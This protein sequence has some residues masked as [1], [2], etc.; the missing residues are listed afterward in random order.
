MSETQNTL[1]L[2]LDQP[3]QLDINIPNFEGKA[4]KDGR[5]GRDGDDA[6]R[7]AVRNGFSGT[8]KEW[9]ETLKGGNDVEIPQ[10]ILSALPQGYTKDFAGVIG[11]LVDKTSFN[12]PTAN[13]DVKNHNIL[14]GSANLITFKD[15]I[16]NTFITFTMGNLSETK[17]VEAGKEVSFTVTP[18]ADDT[19]AMITIK[20]VG[21]YTL[22]TIQMFIVDASTLPPENYDPS[23]GWENVF[24]FTNANKQAITNA[25]NN[26]ETINLVVDF[27]NSDT[28]DDD[29][30]VSSLQNVQNVKNILFNNIDNE[31]KIGYITI[32]MSSSTVY[33]N[34]LTNNLINKLNAT[35]ANDK[36]R[37]IQALM[38]YVN[39]AYINYDKYIDIKQYFLDTNSSYVSTENIFNIN[40]SKKLVMNHST[41]RYEELNT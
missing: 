17:Q 12:A 38:D 40:G 37:I 15:V 3:L 27:S 39:T 19:S 33:I 22:K 30:L 24:N 7:I 6:Y 8:E 41:G 18:K 26:N 10:N 20:S 28:I 16:E 4:G 29:M 25:L 34:T 35:N 2:V 32:Y 21:G 14:R 31:K 23:S 13:T 1:K 9:L 36:W 5:N 11:F